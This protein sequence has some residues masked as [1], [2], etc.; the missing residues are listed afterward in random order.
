MKLVTNNFRLNS[1]QEFITSFSQTNTNVYYIF[2]GR[3][4]PYAND[5]TVPAIYDNEDYLVY[6][7]YND[8][9]YGKRLSSSDVCLMIKRHNWESNT[10]Y[11]KYDDQANNLFNTSFY[12]VNSNNAVFKCLNNAN[13]APTTVEPTIEDPTDEIYIETVDGYQ[14]KYMYTANSV[15]V[16]K[17]ATQEYFPFQE[18]VDVAGNA[19]S[20]AIE[21]ILVESTGALKYTA[22]TTNT[23]NVT[24]VGGNNLIFELSSDA[25]STA[26]IYADSAIFV[27]GINE[28]R[29][30]VQYDANTKQILID[31]VFSTLPN[32]SVTYTIT[33]NILIVGDGTG[34]KARAVVN[35]TTKLISSVIVTNRGEG[36]TFSNVVVQGYSTVTANTTNSP[37]IRAI[38]GPRGGHGKNQAAELGAHWACVATTINSAQSNNK[39]VDENDFRIVGI[40]KNP[41]LREVSLTVNPEFTVD[42]YTIGKKITQSNTNANGVITEIDSNNNII[43]LTSVGGLFNTIDVLTSNAAPAVNATCNTVVGQEIYFDQTLRLVCT[44]SNN[45]I[46]GYFTEDEIVIQPGRET[47]YGANGIFYSSNTINN[48]DTSL[49]RLTHVKGTFNSSDIS[50]EWLLQGTAGLSGQPEANIQ[51][52]ILPDLMH[53]TGEVTYIEDMLPISRNTDQTETFKLI[54]EF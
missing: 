13:G 46:S 6:Q 52:Q 45:D 50:T 32:T 37:T 14:W 35:S 36:Y 5:N 24:A 42:D 11:S 47:Y 54:F 48:G 17:F 30:I 18:N 31:E 33:P 44:N 27:D 2:N 25:S 16:A 7:A 41:L 26:N 3:N 49:I 51:S 20:G 23:F 29:K 40:I 15:Q 19:V 9:I 8:M 39:I 12:V 28:Q 4:Y 22:T 34:A 10:V 21:V 43:T 53:G 38:K 1:A